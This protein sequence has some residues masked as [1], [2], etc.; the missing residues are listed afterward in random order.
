MKFYFL[1]GFLIFLSMIEGKCSTDHYYRYKCLYLDVGTNNNTYKVKCSNITNE[2]TFNYDSNKLLNLMVAAIYPFELYTKDGYNFIPKS[3]TP[4]I[5]VTLDVRIVIFSV[6][7]IIIGIIIAI[8]INY[9]IKLFVSYER[10][11]KCHDQIVSVT[12]IY[13]GIFLIIILMVFFKVLITSDGT[14]EGL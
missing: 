6:L 8:I 12:V 3:E 1:L 13:V 11:Y 2:N 5:C 14:M 7:L 9:L 10:G 4:V